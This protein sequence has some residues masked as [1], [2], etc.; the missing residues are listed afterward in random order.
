MHVIR[1]FRNACLAFSTLAFA[2]AACGGSNSGSVTDPPAQV[3]VQIQ[4]PALQV[5]PGG[6]AAFTA[7]VSGTLNTSVQWE[8]TETAGGTIDSSGHYVA[9]QVQGQATFHVVARSVVDPTC[10]ATAVV[11][12][13]AN[14]QPVVSVTI[15]PGSPSV[16][17]G[18]TVSFS[19]TVTGSSNTNVTWS[20][21]ESSGGAVSPTGTYTAPGSAGTFHVVAT[22]VADGSAAATAT[23]TVTSASGGGGG[24]NVAGL[25]AQMAVL[26]QRAIFFEHA[27]VG[28]NVEDGID[29]LRDLVSGARPTIRFAVAGSVGASTIAAA[30]QP[31][32]FFGNWFPSQNGFPFAKL[33][34]FES[35][36]N[37][38][39][40]AKA[41]IAM[42]KFCFT[43]LPTS[44]GSVTA[45][46]VF[47]A[48]RA[49]MTRLKAAYPKV[50][51]V[52]WTMPLTMDGPSSN[53]P[54]ERFND[55]IRS[56]YGGIDPVFDLALV[57]STRPDG[58]RSLDGGV[59]S[60]Y[61][62]YTPAGDGGH[63]NSAGCDVV[64]RAL[65][66]LLANL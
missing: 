41:D 28:S 4:P 21:Q 61:S 24:G 42:M 51:F 57:E 13:L 52:H 5:Q 17:T 36:I 37:G 58:S 45:N 59:P 65:V 47:D 3:A 6:A 29:G 40:G 64:A 12:V 25:A 55:L 54:R 38:G 11:T 34:T 14:P 63:L 62:G 33:S 60:M 10:H 31:G 19:A 39:V 1:N 2:L 66:S 50:K 43:D 53:G 48:Y 46:S 8:V 56:T 44:D 22:S 23:V 15:S 9:P 16:A 49:M 20:V 27:S 32:L 7:T 26:A 18:G 35:L 30:L